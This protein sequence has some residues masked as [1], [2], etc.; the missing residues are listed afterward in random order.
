MNEKKIIN[1][2]KELPFLYKVQIS[3]YFL[4]GICSAIA[5]PLTTK[6][7]YGSV[8]TDTLAYRI[9]L[10]SLIGIALSLLWLNIQE[11]LYKYFIH[12]TVVECIFYISLITYVILCRNFDSYLVLSTLI[13]GTIGHVV[14]GG[15]SKLHQQITDVEQYRTDYG[16]FIEIVSSIGVLIGS[17]IS[18]LTEVSMPVAFLL[19]LVGLIGFQVS[20]VYVYLNIIRRNKDKEIS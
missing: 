5:Y 16:F 8:E 15:A 11:R 12:F 7:I 10:S 14:S 20:D 4:A 2:W 1:R 6:L 13:S 19:K 17:T 18:V 3:S 9:V